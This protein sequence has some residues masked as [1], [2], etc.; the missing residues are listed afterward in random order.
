MRDGS[1]SSTPQSSPCM[2]PVYRAWNFRVLIVLVG[3][4]QSIKGFLTSPYIEACQLF[5]ALTFNIQSERSYTLV[6]C[7]FSI[8]TEH[9][10]VSRH[11]ESYASPRSIT[12]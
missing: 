7:S 5:T 2:L 8:S 1:K 4:S 9:S 6:R 12:S 10:G 3:L 11:A